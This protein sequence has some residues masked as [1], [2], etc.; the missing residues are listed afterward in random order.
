[1]VQLKCECCFQEFA[2][3]S[4][5]I[6]CSKK[7]HWFCSTCVKTS[8]QDVD[9]LKKRTF[10]ACF[11]TDS[12]E[13]ELS[14]DAVFALLPASQV[15]VL[16]T[17]LIENSGCR[18]FSCY[19]CTSLFS[20]DKED[21]SPYVDCHACQTPHCVRCRKAYHGDSLCDQLPESKELSEAGATVCPNQEC[22]NRRWISVKEGCNRL[23][24]SSC[25]Y[26]WCAICN[27]NITT[28]GYKHFCEANYKES[29]SKCKK[30]G[31]DHRCVFEKTRS[32]G[33]RIRLVKRWC[34]ALEELHLEMVHQCEINS[35]IVDDGICNIVCALGKLK[36]QLQSARAELEAS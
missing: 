2:E 34:L 30:R 23:T 35:V 19:K 24:C 26:A 27:Q 3:E 18:L 29:T 4:P 21:K 11:S 13:G 32:A 25:Q 8:L 28:I 12:C 20:V 31:C 5:G 16:E 36:D 6:I 10:F 22:W 15:Q 7:S 14:Q 17:R 9:S 33:E 1:M